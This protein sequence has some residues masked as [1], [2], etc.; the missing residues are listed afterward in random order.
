MVGTILY[1]V[2]VDR[3]NGRGRGVLW[4][5]LLAYLVG[6]TLVGGLLG[7]VGA[8][9]TPQA[10]TPTRTLAVLGATGV[11][12]LLYGLGELSL[13]R[14][15]TPR[16]RRQVPSG[17]RLT[18][19]RRKLMA[20]VYGFELGVGFTTYVT[21]TTFYVVALWIVLAGSPLLGV[22]TMMGF[23]LGRAVPMLMLSRYRGDTAWRSRL[24][25]G[26]EGWT[27]LVHL[28]NGLILGFCGASFLVAGLITR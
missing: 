8:L 25:E 22:L 11:A 23:G 7:A 10:A 15:P 26:L 14:V 4:A 19:R 6:S 12:A 24:I 13:L 28:A 17:L 16:V 20:V 9:L 18:M 2:N 5:H 1:V 3:E 21:A 27:P